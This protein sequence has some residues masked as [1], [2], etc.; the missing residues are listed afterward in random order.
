MGSEYSDFY[1]FN[2]SFGIILIISSI[3]FPSFFADSFVSLLLNIIIFLLGIILF[4]YGFYYWR[5]KQIGIDTIDKLAIIEA[6]IKINRIEKDELLTKK[7]KE[8]A[9]V[10]NEPWKPRK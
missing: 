8:R 4:S 3:V 7:I 9:E 6:Y 10:I 1:K 5:Q 2:T